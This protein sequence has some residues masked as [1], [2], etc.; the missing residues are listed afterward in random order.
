MTK[1]F[2]KRMEDVPHLDVTVADDYKEGAYLIL[3]KLRPSWPAKDIIF[4]VGTPITSV[5]SFDFQSLL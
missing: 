3:E 1:A 2:R 4:K 5:N